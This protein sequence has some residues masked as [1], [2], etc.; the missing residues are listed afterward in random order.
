MS[1]TEITGNIFYRVQRAAFLGGRDHLVVNNIF[2]DC[3]PA[4]EVDGRGL[5]SSPVWRGW[6]MTRCASAWRR[7]R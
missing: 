3:D 2:V 7:S 1:G 4:V 6:C 5:D